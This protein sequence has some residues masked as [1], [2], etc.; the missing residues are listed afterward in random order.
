MNVHNRL[1]RGLD[2]TITES[3]SQNPESSSRKIKNTVRIENHKE[4]RVAALSSESRFPANEFLPL[5][6]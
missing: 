6:F 4:A 3:R 5:N 2:S 1:G